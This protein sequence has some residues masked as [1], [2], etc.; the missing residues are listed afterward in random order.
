MFAALTDA[1]RFAG[2][3]ELRGSE[4]PQFSSFEKEDT[5]ILCQTQD[6]LFLPEMKVLYFH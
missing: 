3:T 2:L 4:F 6:C 5:K 1:W